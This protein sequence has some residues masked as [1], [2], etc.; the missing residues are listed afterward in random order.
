MTEAKR[1]RL[2]S[3]V[4][5]MRS[6]EWPTDSKRRKQM[7]RKEKCRASLSMTSDQVR[8]SLATK[9][10]LRKKKRATSSFKTWVLAMLLPEAEVEVD[11][12]SIVDHP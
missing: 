2:S 12:E 8:E 7:L 1:P 3:L 10:V 11:L 6:S 9:Q 4:M 5:P